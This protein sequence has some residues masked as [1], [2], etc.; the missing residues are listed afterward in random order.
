MKRYLNMTLKKLY[1]RSF[2]KINK[3]TCHINLLYAC[4]KN[5]QSWHFYFFVLLMISVISINNNNGGQSNQLPDL[6]LENCLHYDYTK[7]GNSIHN[8]TNPEKFKYNFCIFNDC[9]HNCWMSSTISVTTR[10]QICICVCVP[11]LYLC[12]WAR[13]VVGL[14]VKTDLH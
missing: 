10:F 5:T 3:I 1:W 13:N 9:I 2:Y 8:K 14:F 11:N 12:V 6:Q 4:Y 7:S